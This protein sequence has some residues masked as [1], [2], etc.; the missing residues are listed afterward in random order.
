MCK[1]MISG[2]A[3]NFEKADVDVHT[4]LITSIYLPEE[5]FAILAAALPGV[6]IK[7]LGTGYCYRFHALRCSLTSFKAT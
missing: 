5:E 2:S 3:T 1:P 7:K 4:R 6:R